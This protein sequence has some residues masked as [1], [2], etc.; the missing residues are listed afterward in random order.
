[1]DAWDGVIVVVSICMCVVLSSKQKGVD[2]GMLDQEARTWIEE[3][4]ASPERTHLLRVMRKLRRCKQAEPSDRER[5]SAL[6]ALD[7][8]STWMRRELIR[9]LSGMKDAEP[10]T[11]WACLSALRGEDDAWV[12]ELGEQITRLEVKNP[13]EGR[14]SWRA[15]IE[16]LLH[17][18]R[19]DPV[20]EG[21]VCIV[22]QLLG[23]EGALEAATPSARSEIAQQAVVW[24]EKSKGSLLRRRASWLLLTTGAGAWPHEELLIRLLGD[25]DAQVAAQAAQTLRCLKKISKKAESAL[26][27]SLGH[28]YYAVR[29]YA[30]EALKDHPR[31]LS[32]ERLEALQRMLRS[33]EP[34]ERR[35]AVEALG[36]LAR[37]SEVDPVLWSRM[38][39]DE[40]ETISIAAMDALRGWE[41]DL[42]GYLP[43]LIEQV[44]HTSWRRRQNAAGVM[45]R[46]GLSARSAI[47]VL[48]AALDDPR[49]KVR[50]SIL[51]ALGQIDADD[52]VACAAL[53]RALGDEAWQNR[54]CAAELLGRSHRD[55][56]F[57]VDGLLGV[58]DDPVWEVRHAAILALGSLPLG[59]LP[60]HSAQC[61]D[62]LIA[63]LSDPAIQVAR[64]CAKALSK[65]AS[66]DPRALVLPSNKPPGLRTCDAGCLSR[67]LIARFGAR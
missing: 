53:V 48:S 56:V 67:G 40:D 35:I 55:A 63:R 47:P 23:H 1:M 19:E 14:E 27:V 31:P 18:L 7:T 2:C 20:D 3:A 51:I 11:R 43:P 17:A 4:V 32:A 41:V 9:L 13:A 58:L 64:V 62:A 60:Q 66:S 57:R 44:A 39:G 45:G 22:F 38:L 33:E 25:E 10:S 65:L 59:S 16:Q 46:A 42:E 50:R 21:F 61:T 24:L 34:W 8:I 36:H 5:L 54:M 28:P 12:F 29:G 6:L 37:G 52:S 30:A 49:W 15:L 26:E